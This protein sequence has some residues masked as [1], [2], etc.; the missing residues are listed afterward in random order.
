MS[1]SLLI[2]NLATD[3]DDPILAF[4]TEW[5]NRLALRYSHIDVITMRAGRLAVAENVSV[6]SVG[7]EKGYSEARRAAEF[8]RLLVGLLARTRYIACFAHM[9]PLFALMGAPLLKPLGI[10]I[11]LWYTHRQT[12]RT[13]ALAT[14]VSSRLVTAAPDSFPIPTPKLRVL[15]HGIDSDFFRPEFA[16][17]IDPLNPDDETGGTRPRLTRTQETVIKDGHYIIQV[18]R[19]MPIKHQDTLVRAIAPLENA[20]IVLVG[21]APPDTD[22]DYEHMLRGLAHRLELGARVAFAGAQPPLLVREYYHRASIAVN[23]SPPGLFDKA[24]LESMMM[25]LPTIVANPAFDPLLG[26]Y[27]ELLRIAS[28]E[29]VEGLSE[30][31][32]RLLALIPLERLAIGAALRRRAIGAHS[33]SGLIDRLDHVLRTGEPTDE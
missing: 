7:K 33:L 10:R 1:E 12:S 27:A 8:Y 28:P 9:M 3:A 26:D 6:Y 23:L 24:V 2:F 20:R 31:L 11:I 15:G 16:D 13:L 17:L 22:G 32:R 19:L 18:A 21:G 30:R 25:G 4:T 5:I 14:A 29:D